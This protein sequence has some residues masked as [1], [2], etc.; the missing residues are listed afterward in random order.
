MAYKFSKQN[1]KKITGNLFP[2]EKF[3]FVLFCFPFSC[4]WLFLGF[5]C[6]DVDTF[7]LINPIDRELLFLVMLL[8]LD[9]SSEY[10]AH[11]LRKIVSFFKLQI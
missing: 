9:G 6:V 5:E 11:E 8:I 4:N 1:I 7:Q 3:M 2:N 10:V